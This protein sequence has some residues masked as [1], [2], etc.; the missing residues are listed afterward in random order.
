[1]TT[2]HPDTNTEI[3]R[4]AAAGHT[5]E[6]I[7]EELAIPITH[8]HAVTPQH[9]TR[10]HILDLWH[11]GIGKREIS[12]TLLLPLPTIQAVIKA[13]SDHYRRPPRTPNTSPG[14][15]PLGRIERLL[16]EAE[17]SPRQRTRTLAARTRD[18][19]DQLRDVLKAEDEERR[20]QIAVTQAEAELA[21]AR[22]ALRQR[23][24]R[25]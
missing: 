9:A 10:R 18:L 20:I 23:Q 4:L 3:L 17:A 2:Y 12:A 16:A 5:P 15:S 14:T 1:M 8:V 11:N 7:A 21:K 19:L 22:A 25:R 24:N 6:H 13:G